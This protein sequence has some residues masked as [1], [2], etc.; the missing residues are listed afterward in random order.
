MANEKS[1]KKQRK[2]SNLII[3]PAFQYKIILL[4]IGFLVMQ[5]SVSIYY[6]HLLFTKLVTP[7]S[8]TLDPEI[9]LDTV[10]QL[11]EEL[12]LGFLVANIAFVIFSLILAIYFSHSLAGPAYAIHKSI[13]NLI[14]GVDHNEIKLREGDE[15]HDLAGKINRLFSDYKLIKKEDEF[16]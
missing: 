5:A 1:R 8:P 13:N 3:N 11:K 4:V 10:L 16:E 15:Y 14:D 7:L 6:I 12:I 9:T 2:I